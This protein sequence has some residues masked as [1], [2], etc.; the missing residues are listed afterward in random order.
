MRLAAA[1]AL[2]AVLALP[3]V[4]SARQGNAHYQRRSDQAIAIADRTKQVRAEGRKHPGLKPTAY[5]RGAGHWQVSYF[6]GDKE[7]V[8]T[9]VYR[10]T[11]KV[12]EAWTGVQV[13]WQMAR[14]Y[15]GDFGR[16]VNAPYIWLPLCALF[17]LPFVDPRRPFRLIHLDLLVLLAFG[18]SHIYFNRGEVFTSVPLV[19]PVLLYVLVRMLAA[20]LRPRRRRERLVPIVPVGLL[21]FALV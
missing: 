7:L 21:A 2:G 12:L 3:P 10:P 8:Q 5:A 19:Y 17:L 16:H 11:G 6:A 20:G 15:P 1:V 4:A 14:G 13:A 9:L 18:V